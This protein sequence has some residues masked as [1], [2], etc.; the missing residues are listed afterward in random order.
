MAFFGILDALI[1]REDG[2]IVIKALK[3]VFCMVELPKNTWKKY[4]EKNIYPLQD[5]SRMD[6][7]TKVEP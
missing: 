1:S 6:I 2:S 4:I 7:L 5:P 3:F